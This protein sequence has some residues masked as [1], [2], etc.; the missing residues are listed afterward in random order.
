MHP[1][2]DV[3]VMHDYFVDRLVHVG[4]VAGVME[5]VGLKARAG[6]GG[7]HGTSQEEIRGG[8]AV[9]LAYALC[10]LG[11]RTLLITHCERAEGQP[12]KRSFGGLKAEVRTKPLP[13]GLTVA[14]E[15][16]VNV[17]LTDG[18]GASDFGPSLLDESDWRGLAGSRVVCSVNWAANRRGTELLSALRR[19]LG[20]EKTIFVDLADFRDQMD[21]FAGLF[22]A[23]KRER[24]ADWVSMNEHEARAAAA[25]AG[26]GG[27]GRAETCQ[28][29]AGVLRAV[30]DMH[31]VDASFTSEG[32]R[33][34]ERKT[35]V[36]RPKRLTGAGD[37][38]DAASIFGRLDGMEEGERLEF[39]NRAAKM[40]LVN[41]EPEPPTLAQLR[42]R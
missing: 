30:F 4:D 5:E 38:W 2:F 23:L 26:V 39:A 17:M 32:T 41:P 18:R 19:R 40:Y 24:L 16:K 34:T 29:L 33:V 20:P 1:R 36:I 27:E 13:A 10:R 35:K 25:V 14:F 8:N 21:R 7:V 9:N 22:D 6:G 28:A 11:L 15:E 3:A 42:R 12:L 31:C 37:V